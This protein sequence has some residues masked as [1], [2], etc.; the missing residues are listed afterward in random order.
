[1]ETD[2]DTTQS[3]HSLAATPLFALAERLKARA[4]NAYVDMFSAAQRVEALG[5]E[6]KVKRGTFGRPELDAHK[7]IAE[8]LGRHRALMEAHNLLT[9]LLG[10]NAQV[11]PASPAKSVNG[12]TDL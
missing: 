12:G 1:M 5:W 8:K 4:D 11:Q 10:P 6:I 7:T 9:E 2:T 3:G